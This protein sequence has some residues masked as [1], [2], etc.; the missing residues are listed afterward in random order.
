MWSITVSVGRSKF[1]SGVH[2]KSQLYRQAFTEA[3]NISWLQWCNSVMNKSYSGELK[4]L[5]WYKSEC[6]WFVAHMWLAR[7]TK[8][9]STVSCE[10]TYSHPSI[11]LSAVD[12]K[13]ILYTLEVIF[14]NRQTRLT[15]LIS[16]STRWAFIPLQLR[17]FSSLTVPNCTTC[18]TVSSLVFDSQFVWTVSRCCSNFAKPYKWW[19]EAFKWV[20]ISGCKFTN[21]ASLDQ[22]NMVYSIISSRSRSLHSLYGI[23]FKVHFVAL[24]WF[25]VL[26]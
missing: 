15:L 13:S 2:L 20:H 25:L 8:A 17:S 16:L 19:H 6:S 10:T 14:L 11:K 18:R 7:S 12:L 1:L 23:S 22:I 9:V 24:L 5:L 4:L 26:F 21:V 3:I